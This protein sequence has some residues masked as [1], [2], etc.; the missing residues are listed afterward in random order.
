MGLVFLRHAYSRYLNVKDEI[1]AGLPTRGGKTRALKK[2]DFS[3]KSAIFLQ[4]KAQFDYLVSLS[5][6]TDRASKIIEA[7][8]LPLVLQPSHISFLRVTFFI[9]ELPYPVRP[10]VENIGSE[11]IGSGHVRF[12]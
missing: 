1:I 12:Q 8:C 3:Q 9:C 6:S 5:D 10:S 4:E 11:N 2:E 7:P